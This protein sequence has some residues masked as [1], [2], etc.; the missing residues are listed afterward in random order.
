MRV[1]SFPTVGHSWCFH[2]PPPVLESSAAKILWDFSLHTDHHYSSNRPDIV[3]SDYQKKQIYF[4]EISC[5][6]DNVKRREVV[7]VSSPGS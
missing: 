3:L 5:P 4:M 6:A 7:K 2:R 1:Y